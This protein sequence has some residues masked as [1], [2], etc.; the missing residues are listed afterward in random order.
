MER[1]V[2][3]PK[4]WELFRSIFKEGDEVIIITEDDEFKWGKIR[5]TEMFCNLTRPG[6]KEEA[7]FWED[8]RW[9][10]HEGFPVRKLTGVEGK[11]LIETLDTTDIQAFVRE[12][13]VHGVCW[14]CKAVAPAETLGLWR[15]KSVCGKCKEEY[16]TVAKE[17]ATSSWKPWRRSTFGDPFMIEDF[18]AVVLNAGNPWPREGPEE[19]LDNW[20]YT[21]E[22]VMVALHRGG[23]IGL[24]W[25]F[26]TII[27]FE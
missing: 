24:L 16:Q 12:A 1:K 27:H 26:S 18:E 23:A 20:N 3:P 4:A 15:G 17:A 19:Y 5:T 11:V 9:V 7:I 22:E 14:K 2:I 10:S 25:D 8:I 6:R 13:L 21:F